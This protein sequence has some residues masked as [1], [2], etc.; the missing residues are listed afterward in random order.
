M[1]LSEKYSYLWTIFKGLPFG[2]GSIIIGL[3]LF[4]NNPS[5]VNEL[6][7]VVGKIEWYGEKKIYMQEIDATGN[8]FAIKIASELYYS[9]RKK[10]WDKLK[11]ELPIACKNNKEVIIWIV[12]ENKIKQLSIDGNIVVLYKPYGTAIFFICFG[13]LITI[14][15]IIYALK[16]KS[17][18]GF[19]K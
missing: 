9:E 13:V 17:D 12:P 15:A 18:I 6:E 5:D 4:L 16:Y 14:G 8:V 2:I 19:K 11:A 3:S 10:V 7:K 1:G